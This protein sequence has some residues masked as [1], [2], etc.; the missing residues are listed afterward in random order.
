MKI[1]YEELVSIPLNGLSHVLEAL[2]RVCVLGNKE[3]NNVNVKQIGPKSCTYQL[4]GNKRG[5]PK[6][7]R[8]YLLPI[9]VLRTKFM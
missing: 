2:F 6:V 7:R 3:G 4:G 5:P 1:K 9:M 8:R